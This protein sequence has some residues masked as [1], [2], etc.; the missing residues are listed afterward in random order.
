MYV[1]YLRSRFGDEAIIEPEDKVL[2]QCH[3][4]ELMQI[5]RGE[6]I[7]AAVLLHLLEGRLAYVWVG[8]PEGLPEDLFQGAFSAMY[9]FTILHGYRQ[10]CHE[11]DFLGSRP[12]L[13]DGLFRYKRK[14]GTYITDSPVPRG[15]ILL[16]PQRL[17][18]PLQHVFR[19]NPFIVR[20]RKRLVGKLLWNGTP[21]TEEDLAGIYERHFTPGL[22]ALKVFSL[23]GF[24]PAARAWVESRSLPLET[25][26]LTSVPEPAVAFRAS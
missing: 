21:A 1:P 15:D 6:K 2:R 7:V 25:I 22:A 16:R 5:L 14:W 9:Y 12:L 10:G 4:G 13:S 8:V 11:I 18:E 20:D 19:R 3:K 23:S 24:Q 26:D 17:D